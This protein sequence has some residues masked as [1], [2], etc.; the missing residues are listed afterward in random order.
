MGIGGVKL[1][2]ARET[3]RQKDESAPKEDYVEMAVSTVHAALIRNYPDL[4][5]EEVKQKIHAWEITALYEVM[6][7]LWEKDGL[8]R[9]QEERKAKKSKAVDSGRA[10][11]KSQTGAST[12]EDR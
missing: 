1:L 12:T 7:A 5:L 2:A 6:A 10:G 8:K 3:A 11:R 9:L 4:K